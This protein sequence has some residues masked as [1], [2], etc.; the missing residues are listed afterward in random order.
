MGLRKPPMAFSEFGVLMLSNVI[1]NKQAIKVSI[2]IIRLF[3]RMRE[4][5][6][7][8]KDILQKLEEL[9]RND[10]AQDEKIEVIF[11]YLEQFE[12]AKH[13]EIEQANHQKIGFIKH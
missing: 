6:I 13:E 1:N 9:Q 12:K 3:T 8:H 4:M 5:L 2:Q 7:S 11:R 10:I